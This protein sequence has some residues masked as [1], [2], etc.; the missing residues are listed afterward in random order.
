MRSLH[1]LCLVTVGPT[2]GTA[3]S[4][5]ANNVHKIVQVPAAASSCRLPPSHHNRR[6]TQRYRA[7]HLQAT[8]ALSSM[9]NNKL[10]PSRKERGFFELKTLI[11]VLFPAIISGAVAYATLPTLN[12]QIASFVQRVSDPGKISM[13]GDAVQSF[14]SLVGLLYSILVGQVFG[15]LYSQQEALYLALFDEVTEAKS[16]LEQVALV[17]QGRTMYSTCLNS[18]ARYVKNDLLEGMESFDG[19]ITPS[20]LLSARPSDDPLEAILYLTSVGVP[21]HV[22]DTVRSLRQARSRR[23]GAL[24]RKVPVIHLI[25]LW[26][27]GIVMIGSFPVFLGVSEAAAAMGGLISRSNMTVQSGLFGVATF[28][29]VMCKSVLMELW[30][31][32]GG[33]YNVDKTLKVMVSGLKKELDERM[34]EAKKIMKR[35]KQD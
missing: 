4:F 24:Q 25:M 28:S 32:K 7:T 22:Y 31:T 19:S 6:E 27:L 20:L 16:L 8:A 14:I 23:L 17:S 12:N 33:A 30:R 29:V 5:P 13:L 10:F 1:L 21:G 11:R 9:D 3:F 18:I 26:L 2:L 35:S 34:D 15:F